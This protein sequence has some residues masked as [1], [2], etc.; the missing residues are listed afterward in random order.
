MLNRPNVSVRVDD[1]R[2]FLALSGERFDVITADIIQPFHA[3]AGHLYSR[4]YFTLVRQALKP[5]GLAL[6]WIGHRDRSHYLLIMRTFLEVFPDATLWLQG[7]LMVG[8]PAPLSLNRSAFEDK[9][10]DPQSGAV[11]RHVGLDSFDALRAWYAAGPR[12]MK[13]FVGDGPLLT[14]DRPLVEYHR[15]LPPDPR[16]LD[17]SVIKGSV[18]ELGAK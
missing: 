8:S 1:G 14:D 2:N 17:L 5:G 13:A 16:P 18:D 3:G 15:S 11:M 7:E 10:R 9:L 4:E 12:E 6:Q